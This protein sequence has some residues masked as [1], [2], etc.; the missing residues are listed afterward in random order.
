[1]FHRDYKDT[2]L[3]CISFEDQIASLLTQLAW[4]GF[5]VSLFWA[6]F[7]HDFDFQ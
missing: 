5:P 6:Q 2:I 4:K 1:M 7:Y 3:R